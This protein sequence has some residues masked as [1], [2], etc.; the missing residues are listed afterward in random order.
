M[1]D[2]QTDRRTD[3]RTERG[4]GG[5]GRRRR[6][7]R[8]ARGAFPP[9][10]RAP[11][12]L[13]PPE[14]RRP[15]KP[16]AWLGPTEPAAQHSDGSLPDCLP[17]GLDPRA[18]PAECVQR[19]PGE[20]LYSGLH[21]DHPG[22]AGEDEPFLLSQ[23]SAQPAQDW[24]EEINEAMPGQLPT[25]CLARSRCS[26]N[27]SCDG[28]FQALST[29]QGLGSGRSCSATSPADSQRLAEP[30]GTGALSL[31]EIS[32]VTAQAAEPRLDLKWS[33]HRANGPL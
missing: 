6:S 27:L 19:A 31:P 5:R 28:P 24:Y 12:S 9:S 18:R 11:A 2:R 30:P 33:P 3:G 32:S 29:L 15:P 22:D 26:L 7:R 16:L 13:P 25:Q 8:T 20:G 23:A 14:D 21:G 1:R 10:S 4:A 17:I